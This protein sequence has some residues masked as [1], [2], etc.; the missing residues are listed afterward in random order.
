MDDL[1][2]LLEDEKC[3]EEVKEWGLARPHMMDTVHENTSA[4]YATAMVRQQ[5]QRADASLAALAALYYAERPVRCG[6]C[7]HNRNKMVTC[8]KYI[9]RPHDYKLRDFGC[10][11]GQRKEDDDGAD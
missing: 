7:R 8:A 5:L 6:E 10:T 1:Q 2:R 3:P 11:E 9:Q 4:A